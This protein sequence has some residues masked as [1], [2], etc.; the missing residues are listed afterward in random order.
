ML[1]AKRKSG[2]HTHKMKK[3]MGSKLASLCLGEDNVSGI[4]VCY[5]GL[6][7]LFFQHKLNSQNNSPNALLGEVRIN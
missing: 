2:L 6:Q 1:K 7:T 4:C 3:I 5:F